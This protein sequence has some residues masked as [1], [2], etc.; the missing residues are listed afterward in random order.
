MGEKVST[1]LFSKRKT[2]IVL[3]ATIIALVATF[4]TVTVDE[5]DGEGYV[6]NGV[7]YW[8]YNG[9]ASVH[10]WEG[11][12]SD[13]VIPSYL[14]VDGARYKVTSV[15]EDAFQG[16]ESLTSVTLPE[17]IREI[18]ENAFRDCI[19]LRTVT[20]PDRWDL[21][22]ISEYA[23]EGCISL[24]SIVLP[25]GT[26]Q[27]D[28]CAFDGCRSLKEVV[29]PDSLE[30]ISNSFNDCDAVQ[31]L[32]LP[33]EYRGSLSFLRG[34]GGLQEI[35][36]NDGM[37]EYAVV[38][39]AVYD[40][41]METLLYVPHAMS[42]TLR[43]PEGVVSVNSDDI[44]NEHIRCVEIPSTVTNMEV[45]Y[46]MVGLEE[47][48]VSDDNPSFASPDGI[49]CSKDQRTLIG[50]PAARTG[51]FTVPG[52]FQNIGKLAFMMSNLESITIN[53][54]MTY[55]FST[56]ASSD[57][58]S[59]TV[60][61][62]A[63]AEY[64][65]FSS[66]E[67]LEEVILTDSRSTTIGQNAFTGCS[68]LTKV[69]IPYFVTSIGE[70]SFTGCVNLSSIDLPESL[71]SI[72]EG[73]FANTGMTFVDIP[74]GVRSIPDGCFRNSASLFC[75][76]IPESVGSIGEM[77]FSGCEVAMIINDS[78]LPITIGNSD[79]GGIALNAIKIIRSGEEADGLASSGDNTFVFSKDENGFYLQ[80]F[81]GPGG[82]LVLPETFVY[83]SETVDSYRLTS[84]QFR[85]NGSITSVTIPGSVS[86][87]SSWAFHDCT[88]LE[89]VTLLNGVKSIGANAFEGCT[90]LTDVDLGT[91]VSLDSNLF[92][93][94]TSLESITIPRTVENYD[95]L[96]FVG[97][98]GLKDI[99]VEKGHPAFHTANGAVYNRY[100]GELTFI[101]YGMSGHFAIPDG[102]VGSFCDL[103]NFPNLTSI[104][105]PA[106]VTHLG[107]N[108]E[109]GNCPSLLNIE[110]HPDN[111]EY[112][113][114]DGVL[115]T[116]DG[117]TLLSFPQGREGAYSIPE[118]TETIDRSSF[119]G[120]TG[121]TS[122][123][124]PD[125]LRTIGSE[126]FRYCTSVRTVTIPST[127]D[128][129][130][131]FAFS[132]MDSLETVYILG[133]NTDLG[134]GCFRESGDP[135]WVMS[136]RDPGFLDEPDN[137]VYQRIQDMVTV[138]FEFMDESVSYEMVPGTPLV[139]PDLSVPGYRIVGWTPSIPAQVPDSSTSFTAIYEKETFTVSFVV[140]GEVYSSASVEFGDPI[141]LPDDP[142]R[143]GTTFSHWKGLPET[144]PAEDIVATAVW[145][146]AVDTTGGSAVVSG[147]E[148]TISF[149]SNGTSA[150]Y[151]VSGKTSSGTDETTWSVT[152]PGDR[153][154]EGCVITVSV[155]PAALA[156]SN[157]DL[158][159]ALG[160]YKDHEPLPDVTIA[161][162]IGVEIPDSVTGVSA[163]IRDET[164][165]SQE[166]D[167]TV[168]G[169]AVLFDIKGS[170]TV[171]F[172]FEYDIHPS[173][174]P[175]DTMII[176]II[177]LIVIAIAALAIVMMRRRRSRA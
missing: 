114:I 72:G 138:T 157:H 38:D 145:A 62:S 103:N 92:E 165:A 48:R 104:Y 112:R 28:R 4:A 111:P 23:F 6:Q 30:Y 89:R 21:T 3:A 109:F 141:E 55:S 11:E 106:S 69:I 17:T 26:F 86:E 68:S 118:G 140:D 40:E 108:K 164:G 27:L 161:C 32:N 16:C 159:Y 57:I 33:R 96:V 169:D 35:T 42:G 167:C 162:S 20:M 160:I 91:V 47:Y 151:T 64:N 156:E 79:Y 155:T 31:S 174:I 24:E 39:N 152:I 100:T 43:I 54:D 126:A 71:L 135:L 128:N 175:I 2:S 149:I 77:A 5:V 119:R 146:S 150:S 90:S 144:M 10:G 76:H 73:A 36:A 120:T 131:G 148:D 14:E 176:V 137:I 93:D 133:D 7:Y 45:L 105:I 122:I 102:I 70:Y 74:S 163:S 130:E 15:F 22:V 61:V 116:K 58:V 67:K 95:N 99:L 53:H 170:G 63:V 166:I 37:T 136:T 124:F 107:S 153:L 88:N 177:V 154:G 134:F 19:A 44:S 65:S 25:E 51:D 12:V 132:Y 113:S 117:K 75:I 78:D 49:L 29:L 97:A 80:G 18:R 83:G 143:P 94:C 82:D 125:S 101:A 87:V 139:V 121:L 127:V 50:F 172:D 168:D 84:N 9:N 41:N 171:S 46:A 158:A 34:M 13:V 110:V 142:R 115:F 129:V 60:P 59:A 52:N 147:D 81:F 173:V 123:S 56:F 66:C 98:S 1:L 85:G 8:V